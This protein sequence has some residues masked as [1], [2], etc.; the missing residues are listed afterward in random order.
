MFAFSTKQKKPV[1]LLVEDNFYFRNLLCEILGESFRIYTAGN[2]LE[3]LML[4]KSKVQPDA[5]ITD[6][7]MPEMDGFDFIKNLKTSGHFQH[8]PVY[9]ISGTDS[10]NV[11]HAFKNYR[12]EDIFMKPFNPQT[13]LDKLRQKFSTVAA[14]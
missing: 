4:M 8:I 9:I 13:L 5:I 14:N 6:I 10:S 3:A 1:L 11:K 2:G 12:I 7:L